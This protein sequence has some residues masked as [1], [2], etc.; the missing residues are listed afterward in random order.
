MA[1]NTGKGWRIGQQKDRYQVR[2]DLTDRFDKYDG[3]ANFLKSKL[4]PGPWKG[5]EER[6]PKKP[7]RD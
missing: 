2:N 7:P 3:A 5:V 1:K 4:M 6:K